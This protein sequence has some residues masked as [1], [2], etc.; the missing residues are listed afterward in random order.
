MK[1]SLG[2]LS[3]IKSFSKLYE[4]RDDKVIKINAIIKDKFH[5]SLM[6]FFGLVSNILIIK[7]IKIKK[8][9]KANTDEAKLYLT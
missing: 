6:I 5:L 3:K 9:D 8:I 2:I 7:L 1:G 4:D